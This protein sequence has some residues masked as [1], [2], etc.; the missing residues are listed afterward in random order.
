M[1]ILKFYV[2]AIL[3]V[4]IFRNVYGLYVAIIMMLDDEEIWH[5]FTGLQKFIL[6]ETIPATIGLIWLIFQII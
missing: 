2:I 5:T 4:C 6:V 1:I 3:I